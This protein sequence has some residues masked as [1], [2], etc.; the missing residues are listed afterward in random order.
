MTAASTRTAAL[1][2]CGVLALLALDWFRIAGPRWTALGA[3]RARLDVHRTELEAARE[4]AAARGDTRRAV[5]ATARALRR[6]ETRLPDR[7]ELS[8]LLAAVAAGA[9]AAHLAVPALRPKPE[10]V[11]PDHVEVPVELELRGTWAETTAFLRSL[12]GLGRLV[13]VGA[14]RLERPRRLGERVV[15]D[16]RATL[17]TYRVPDPADRRAAPAPRDR[18]GER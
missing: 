5:R 2:A 10:R 7:R 17:L 9:R 6:A 18:G 3:A 15:V 14:L 13:H 11:A 8:G 16:G 1:V 4:E 12:E